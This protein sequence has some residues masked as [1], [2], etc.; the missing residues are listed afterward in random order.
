M[1]K[2]S[3]S[4]IIIITTIISYLIIRKFFKIAPRYI[5]YA[6]IGIFIGLII[7]ITIAWP[8]SQFLGRFGVI[9]APYVLGLIVMIFIEIFIIEGGKIIKILRERFRKVVEEY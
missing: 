3:F 5:F 8:I 2:R 9:I 4:I 6:A 7:G 1:D